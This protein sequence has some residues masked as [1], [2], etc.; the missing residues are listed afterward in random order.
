MILIFDNVFIVVEDGNVANSGNLSTQT[1]LNPSQIGG[2][3]TNAIDGREIVPTIFIEME[4][5]LNY[6]FEFDF[7]PHFID[8]VD[9]EGEGDS[10]IRRRK[11]SISP[12]RVEGTERDKFISF[13]CD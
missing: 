13:S 5:E 3:S 10:E 8:T 12:Q 4:S 2:T 11:D 1:D 6:F 7:F 9:V